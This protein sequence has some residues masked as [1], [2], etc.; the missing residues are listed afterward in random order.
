MET[1][2]SENEKNI[3]SLVHLST[4][5]KYFFPFAN[6]LAPLLLWTFHKEKPFVSEHGR[7]AVNFQLSILLYTLVIGIICLPFFVIFA[8]DF[9]SLAEA[10]DHHAHHVSVYEVNNMSGYILL[11]SIVA[12]LLFGLFVFELYAVISATVNASKGQPYKYPLC[13]SFIKTSTT[14]P[15]VQPSG[16]DQ[17]QSENEHVS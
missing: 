7:Q 13:I 2:P 12:L 5:S 8:A 16:E 15:A 9:V 3:A 11:F 17:N 4:F 14:D 6:F 1:T 10:I